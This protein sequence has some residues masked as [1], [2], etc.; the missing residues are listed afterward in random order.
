MPDRK[1]ARY[2]DTPSTTS[3]TE[4][5]VDDVDPDDRDE[6]LG[7][8]STCGADATVE[9]ANALDEDL[10]EEPLCRDCILRTLN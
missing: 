10:P 5:V 9:D 4:P 6:Q 1:L 8:C 7:E 3:P 2:R